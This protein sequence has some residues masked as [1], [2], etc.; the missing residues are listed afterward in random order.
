MVLIIT[1]AATSS[2]GVELVRDVQSL[3][4][5]WLFS[6]SDAPGS[7]APDFDDSAWTKLNVP[8]D[9]SIEGPFATN[10]PSQGKGGN[11]PTGAVW[12]RKS[13]TLPAGA[14]ES[15]KRIFVDFDGIM[16]NSDVWINGVHLGKRPYGYVSFQYELTGRLNAA[17]PNIL[18]VRADTSQ[19]PASRWY[20]GG[21]IYRHVRLQI[22]DAVH[23][24]NWGTFVTTPKITADAASVHVRSTVVNQ[25]DTSRDV[26]LMVNILGPDGISVATAE[27]KAQPVPAGKTI[28]FEQDVTVNNPKLW[29][30][31]DTQI[32]T[33]IASVRD[34]GAG[35]TIIDDESVPFGIRSFEFRPE[36]GFWLNG[37]NFKLKGVCLHHDA[38]GLGAAVPEDE[39]IHRLQMLK[40]YG[41]NAVRTAHNPPSPE[42][43]D[44]C[45]KVGMLVMDEMFDCWQVAKNP[46]DYHL[47]FDQWNLIDTRDTV[48]RDRNHPSI[49]L[50]SAGNEIHDT[51]N[52]A[53]ALAILAPLVKTFRENDPTRPVT[54]ALFRPN[55]DGS[56]GAYRN[57][58]SDLLDVVGTNYRDAEMLAAWAAKPTIKIVGTEQ[59]KSLAIWSQCRDNPQ[60]SGQ[61]IWTGV[62]Y[63]GETG[64]YPS[65]AAGAG[66]LDFTNR[67][68][69]EAIE[70]ASWWSTKPVVYMVRSG[71]GFGFDLAPNTD[72]GIPPIPSPAGPGAA[73]GDTGGLPFN[74]EQSNQFS[75][76]TAPAQSPD[77]GRGA[78]RGANRRGNRGMQGGMGSRGYN[79]GLIYT[80]NWTPA[81]LEPHSEVVNVYSNCDEVELFLNGKSLG[82]KSRGAIG[83]ARTWTVDF[84]PGTLK[85]VGKNKGDIVASQELV[86][87]GK[88]AKIVLTPSTRKLFADFDSLAHVTVSITDDKGVEVP[89]ANNIVTFKVSGPGE[90]AALANGSTQ[91]QN[92]RGTEHAA[93]AG[94]LI[95]YIRAAGSDDSITLTAASNGLTSAAIRFETAPARTRR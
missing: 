47:A 46:F 32:Y 71:G 27:T 41:S 42:F 73:A 90:I 4:K 28:D 17:G 63:L 33:A 45:D 85:A 74:A 18:A 36:T 61:F 7:Q 39:W 50:Y 79:P 49:I 22:M 83:S 76:I 75:N 26:S 9:W 3:N 88:A 84:A 58:L 56:G 21:G 86:T 64:P 23:I 81:N 2:F 6:K 48:R 55:Q 82:S 89:A 19:Q 65:I 51:P 60:H 78:A 91:A 44:A 20:S 10:L 30:I 59:G 15:G 34:G 54:Q 87:A 5:D 37:R 95:A 35:G 1:L 92:F 94:Q 8:H 40:Q 80:Y 38:G 72:P 67:P 25:S 12:Y 77:A 62:D 53:K 68:K 66:I 93:L 52:V 24:D 14:V 13:L 29:D 43:L 16:E 31:E 69:N 70:R 57:G 11:A